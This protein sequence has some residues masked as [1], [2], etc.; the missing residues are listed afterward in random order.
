[1]ALTRT[2]TKHLS[3]RGGAA[4]QRAANGGRGLP[5]PVARTTARYGAAAVKHR[6]TAAVA[7]G[8]KRGE[9]EERR[10]GWCG[11]GWR[12]GVYIGEAEGREGIRWWRM[13][14]ERRVGLEATARVMATTT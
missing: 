6:G 7:P 11:E 8:E 5:G 10:R 9:K 14:P 12:P 4:R 2:N 1:M 3:S 13:G